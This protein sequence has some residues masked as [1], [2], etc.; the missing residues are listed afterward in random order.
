M[1]MTFK[2]IKLYEIIK[3]CVNPFVPLKY[4]D[5]TEMIKILAYEKLK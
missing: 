5:I 4:L 1:E 2:V 3:E